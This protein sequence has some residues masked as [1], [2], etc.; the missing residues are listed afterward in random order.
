MDHSSS[1]GYRQRIFAPETPALSAPAGASELPVSAPERRREGQRVERR[2]V[3]GRVE[4]PSHP[5]RQ[6]QLRARTHRRRHDLV[7]SGP[8]DEHIVHPGY[9]TELY[10]APTVGG[11]K[12]LHQG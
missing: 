9:T 12:V 3:P 1:P 4:Q 5:A 10:H 11:G 6:D 2:P 8:D 7:G